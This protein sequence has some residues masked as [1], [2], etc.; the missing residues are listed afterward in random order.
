MLYFPRYYYKPV[1]LRFMERPK[2]MWKG[3]LKSVQASKYLI[4]EE[5]EAHGQ[6]VF[7]LL[8]TQS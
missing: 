2:E 3:I 7:V 4:F 1:V 6:R 8:L 5:L